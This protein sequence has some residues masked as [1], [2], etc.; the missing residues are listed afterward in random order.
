MSTEDNLQDIQAEID[1]LI[2]P[3]RTN[4]DLLVRLG[5]IDGA[6]FASPMDK[7]K[8]GLRFLRNAVERVH[9]NICS[10]EFLRANGQDP[11]TQRKALAIAAALDFLGAQGAA[12]A[13]VL[14]IQIGLENVCGGTW[15]QHVR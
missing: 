5:E 12:T 14:I 9:D 1:Q 7:E 10:N 13:S 6:L 15:E 11:S 2:A 8:R 4:K 3:P